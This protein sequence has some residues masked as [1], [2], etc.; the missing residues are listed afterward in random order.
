MHTPPTWQ[1]HQASLWYN[2]ASITSL[3]RAEVRWK[4]SLTVCYVIP[5]HFLSMITPC[6]TA[7]PCRNTT[8][9]LGSV[10]GVTKTC[11]GYVSML[12]TSVLGRKVWVPV[13]TGRLLISRVLADI[14]HSTLQSLVSLRFWNGRVSCG[15][16]WCWHM[17]LHRYNRWAPTDYGEFGRVWK[18]FNP[19]TTHRVPSLSFPVVLKNR[20]DVTTF[21]LCFQH[22]RSLLTQ[23]TMGLV[24]AI[25]SW[26][27]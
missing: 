17:R 19:N 11:C 25:G 15:F 24:Q 7:W 4:P 12:P 5:L 22:L 16:Q 18:C 23:F 2:E 9:T 6:F 20:R 1:L 10:K 21:I 13:A 3:L 14:A 27:I 8:Y 26:N